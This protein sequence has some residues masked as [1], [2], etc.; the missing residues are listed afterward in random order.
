[1]QMKTFLY[2]FFTLRWFKAIRSIFV[3][4]DVLELEKYLNKPPAMILCCPQGGI[5]RKKL[6]KTLSKLMKGLDM[7]PV[8]LTYN[9]TD[10]AKKSA[11]EMVDHMLSTGGYEHV[12][13]P[14]SSGEYIMGEISKGNGRRA[15][16]DG[17]NWHIHHGWEDG[18]LEQ[19]ER[20]LSDAW[21]TVQTRKGRVSPSCSNCEMTDYIDRQDMT[22]RN[23]GVDIGSDL[24]DDVT[25]VT[26]Y[27]EVTAYEADTGKEIL[28]KAA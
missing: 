10:N 11:E 5:D 27:K 23:C 21:V 3:R 8:G 18:P 24:E 2:Y 19:L 6:I 25:A 12:Y 20:V 16:I 7:A 15:E 17:F 14:H 4:S 22:C 13:L 26:M 9:D 28:P 1:M